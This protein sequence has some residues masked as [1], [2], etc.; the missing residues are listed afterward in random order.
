MPNKKFSSPRIRY[1]VAGIVLTIA[2]ILG[3]VV[4]YLKREWKPI[5]GEQLK[6]LVID[7]SDSLYSITYSDLKFSLITGNASVR[8]FKL[9]PNKKVYQNL[10]RLK[11]APDNVYDLQVEILQIQNFHPKRVY[12]D[13]KLNV[14]RIIIDNPTL[15]ITNRRQLYNNKE[16]D[17]PKSLYQ[18]ISQVFKE[19]RVNEIILKD[20]DFTFENRTNAKA[21]KTEIK[22]LNI[23]GADLLIDSLSE[24]DRSRFF[25][26][27]KI[28][29]GLKSYRIATSD[30]LYY[31]NFKN[32][33]FS[34]SNRQLTLD[35][36]N[37]TPR[38]S[39]AAYYRKVGF[40]KDYFNLN[41][42]SISVN[43]IDLNRFTR[44]QKLF[45]GKISIPKGKISVYNNRAY[46][47]NM[48]D[49]SD[50]FPHRQLQKLALELKIDTLDIGNVDITYAEFNPKSKQTGSITFNNTSGRFLNVTNDAATLKKNRFMQ[51]DLYTTLWNS[52]K[53]A[54][55]FNFNLT[56]PRSAFSYSGS[57]KNM[58]GLALNNITKPLGLIEIKSATINNMSF[59]VTANNKVARGTMRFNYDNLAVNILQKD[60][61]SG[62]LKK[63]GLVSTVANVF[64][65]QEDNPNRKGE[66]TP[67]TI[68]YARSYYESFFSF[69]WRSLFSGVKESVGVSREREGKLRNVAK[70]VG[71]FIGNLKEKREERK[72]ERQERREERKKEKELKEDER[73][74][75]KNSDQEQ[76]NEQDSGAQSP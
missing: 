54:V 35:N 66:F 23:T 6:Q 38:Y 30:S 46:K 1:W 15:F 10:V 56:S 40:A 31:I 14:N 22:N 9:I 36:I 57:L 74:A 73:E 18:S 47:R 42:D 17:T 60:D 72:E 65:I 3:G 19:V 37:L 33:A 7:S 68:Y 32:L 51:A 4:W 39:K 16:P 20:V 45:S 71:S 58:N 12:T 53:L 48:A 8:N 41:F 24:T 44:D 13:K 75:R 76:K 50:K 2:A 61:E 43:S 26:T 29:L 5:L 28:D 59:K 49:K 52:G 11:K 25:H 63:Q 21:K 27:R 69:L 70:K 34:T 55:H 67:G 62:A 64:V